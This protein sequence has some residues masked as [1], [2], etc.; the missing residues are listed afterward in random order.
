MSP[1]RKIK[2]TA[3][4]A[5]AIISVMLSGCTSIGTAPIPTSTTSPIGSGELGNGFT[6]EGLVD[7]CIDRSV[8]S[9]ELDVEYDRASGR[10]EPRAVEGSWLVIVPSRSMERDA[11]SLCVIGGTREEPVFDAYGATQPLSDAEIAEWIAGI[12]G[13]TE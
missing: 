5:A 4:G 13:P 7:L 6:N 1:P 12:P 10:V 3:L 2:T 8:E 11:V 9:Y